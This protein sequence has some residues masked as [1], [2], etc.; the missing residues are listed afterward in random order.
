[1]PF[2][3][4]SLPIATCSASGCTDCPVAGSVH[5]HFRP[6]EL[7][8][9]LL[10]SLP[11]FLVGGAGVLSAGWLPLAVWVAV[12]VGF[13]GFVEIRVLCS[14]CPHYAEEGSS[15]KCWANHGS[16]KLWKYRPGPMS[17]AEKTVLLAGF[18]VVWGYPLAFFVLGGLWFLLGVYLLMASGFFVT[19][20]VYLCSRCMNFACPLNGVPDSVRGAFFERNPVVADAWKDASRD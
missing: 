14:H 9:F 6:A 17:S 1:M 15:L 19:L 12:I 3:D 10:I 2:L 11:T 20:K 16:P 5:C 4:P 18:A 7:V 13:F 8:H